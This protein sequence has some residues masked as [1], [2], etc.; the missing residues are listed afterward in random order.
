M[1]DY[2]EHDLRQS[3][4]FVEYVRIQESNLASNLNIGFFSNNPNIPTD[5]TDF[6][7]RFNVSTES[8]SPVFLQDFVN[9]LCVIQIMDIPEHVDALKDF[10][11]RR[12]TSLSRLRTDFKN[13]VATII[14]DSNTV[15][16][17]A[18]A[19]YNWT[20][21]EEVFARH[22]ANCFAIWPRQWD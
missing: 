18:R 21:R 1:H 5:A 10:K 16:D 11:P 8:L 13:E 2:I 12:E 22:I 19:I 14:G 7:S 17:K 9:S 20:R 15:E 6:K 3:K 4:P